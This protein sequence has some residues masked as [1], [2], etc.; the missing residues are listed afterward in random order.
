[1]A[2]LNTMFKNKS[3]ATFNNKVFS[4]E[5]IRFM[6]KR[7]DMHPTMERVYAAALALKDIKGQTALAEFLNE[8]PQL[9]NNWERRGVSAQGLISVANKIGVSVDYLT[10]NITFDEFANRQLTANFGRSE[11][12]ASPGTSPRKAVVKERFSR[13]TKRLVEELAVAER[14]GWLTPKTVQTLRQVLSLASPENRGRERHTE[15]HV[16]AEGTEGQGHERGRTAT[17]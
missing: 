3:N 6:Q 1:M 2:T 7:I 5:T 14:D 8:S 4:C 11:E 16:L 9:L 13:E 10:G 17:K 12:S 15:H